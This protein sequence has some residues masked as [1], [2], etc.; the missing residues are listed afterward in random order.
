MI[1]R[2]SRR[3]FYVLDFYHVDPALVR[4]L[5]PA[6]LDGSFVTR[7]QMETRYT[8][9]LEEGQGQQVVFTHIGHHEHTPEEIP[10]SLS[11]DRFAPAYDGL[12]VEG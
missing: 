5:D 8:P 7:K 6:I 4:P 9:V 11:G 2:E 12:A 3:V 1:E 10:A